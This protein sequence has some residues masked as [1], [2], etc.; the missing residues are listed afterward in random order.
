MPAT[1]PLELL[2]EIASL[3]YEAGD[4]LVPYTTVCRRWQAAFEPFIYSDLIVYSDDAHKEESQKGI[5]LA[6][7]QKATAG[8]GAIRQ[9]WIRKL[10]VDNP[11]REANDQAFQTAITA[12]FETLSSWNQSHRLSLELGLLGRQ[13]GEEPEPHTWDYEDAGEYSICAMR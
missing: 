11:V 1:L 4:C 9:V 2:S 12:L 3:L 13:M 6:H 8:S 5:S 7:F 10:H